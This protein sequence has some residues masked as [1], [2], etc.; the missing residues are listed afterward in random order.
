MVRTAIFPPMHDYAGLGEREGEKRTHGIER[1]QWSVIPP[2]RMST[3]PHSNASP[4]DRIRFVED[5]K[6]RVEK[7]FGN[8]DNGGTGSSRLLTGSLG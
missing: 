2:K 1:D 3:P 8:K 6:Q 4:A 5:D 7:N